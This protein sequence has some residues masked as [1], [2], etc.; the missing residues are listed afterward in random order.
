MNTTPLL[1]L[2]LGVLMPLA[3]AAQ[4]A[5]A[6]TTEAAP[7][8]SPAPAETV[9]PVTPVAL[10]APKPSGASVVKVGKGELM[11]NF[12]NASLT[13]VLNYL[14]EAAGFIV[15]QDTTIAGTVNVVSKQPVSIDDS[16]DLL[17]SVL[18]DK[19]Y[20]AIRNGRILK[21]VP[22]SG[23]QKM[24]I[25][26][27]SGSDPTQIPR[28]DGMVTQILPVRYVE[29]AKLVENLRPLLSPDATLSANEASNALL[30]AD[31]QTNVHRMAEIIHALDTSVSSISTIHVYT[32]QYA[33]SKSLATVITQLFAT[34]QTTS[35]GGNNRGNNNNQGGRP[36]PP[37][38]ANTAATG[39]AQSA[40]Q[41][42]ATRIIAV[43]DDQSNSV[44][45]S[46]PDAAI[47][48][49]SDIVTRIDQNISDITE[50]R[51][52][53][54]ARADAMELANEFNTL[55]NDTT[56]STTQGGANGSNNRRTGQQIMPVS[57]GNSATSNKSE[58][59]VLLNK[60][61]AVADPRT[62]SLVVSASKDAMPSLALTVERLDAGE[63]K[64]QQVYVHR[65]ENADPNNVATILRGMFSNQNSSSSTSAQPTTGRLNQRTSNG[66]SSDI[67]NTLSN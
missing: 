21:I 49:I 45:V 13:D 20:A 54:L 17:N 26:V 57:T 5:P 14:S 51:I 41:Q 56:S 8:P 39:K 60:V 22:R 31:T 35:S 4:E 62:N 66:A 42:A 3:A 19:G 10:P 64:K 48:T 29:A 16:V 32:L 40:A 37:W 24:D 15:V 53:R 18:I 36:M 30:L 59:A 67:T 33:D 58:R 38:M 63:D 27:Q 2:A 11:L 23:A 12:Q 25:P 52:F 9:A 55:Y 6:P 47:P 61:V 65:L 43:S 28:K 50:T 46:A 1:S 44:I 34:D 7:A